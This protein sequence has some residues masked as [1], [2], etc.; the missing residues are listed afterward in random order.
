[1]IAGSAPDQPHDGSAS[2]GQIMLAGPT[3]TAQHGS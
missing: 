3:S 2:V 1:M